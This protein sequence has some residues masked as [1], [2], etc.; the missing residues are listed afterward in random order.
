MPLSVSGPDQIVDLHRHVW[1]GV[2]QVELTTLEWVDWWN[3]HPEQAEHHRRRDTVITHL[4]PP[5]I[6]GV[7]HLDR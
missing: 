7:R 5:P 1:R 6:D 2:D 3:Q 4:G